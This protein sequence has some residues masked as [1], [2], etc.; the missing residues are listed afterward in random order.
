MYVMSFVFII[1]F[2]HGYTYNIIIHNVLS[3]IYNILIRILD[4]NLILYNIDLF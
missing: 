4:Y 1:L 2:I 3:V